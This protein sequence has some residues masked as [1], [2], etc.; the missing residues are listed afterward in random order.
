MNIRIFTLAALLWL[1]LS[2][3]FSVSA[4]PQTPGEREQ[5][6]TEMRQYKRIYITKELE[7]SREQQAK[8]Y[9]LY[10]EMEENEARINDEARAM[11]KR[12]AET[13]NASDLEYE[14]ATEAVYDAAVRSAQLEREYMEKFKEILS[15]KQLFR[16]KAVERQFNREMMRQHHRLRTKV[17]GA[18]K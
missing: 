11:E 3:S 18:E 15:R 6:M 2:A 9:P 7:L 4:A 12:V 17:K 5:W 14:K 13:Q 8:F 16:L 1:T 10:E